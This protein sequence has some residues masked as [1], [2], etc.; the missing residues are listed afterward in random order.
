MKRLPLVLFYW[1]T[2]GGTP[3]GLGEADLSK[4]H[5]DKCRQSLPTYQ[6]IGKV[7]NLYIPS[8]VG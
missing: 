7:L 4:S 1:D 5:A 6:M 3:G 8:I 2:S